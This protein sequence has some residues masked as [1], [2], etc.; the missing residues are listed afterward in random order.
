MR[1]WER[2]TGADIYPWDRGRAAIRRPHSR[3]APLTSLL[4][5][6]PSFRQLFLLQTTAFAVVSKFSSNCSF[7][8]KFSGDSNIYSSYSRLPNVILA[9][10]Y[11]IF[12]KF[13]P[14]IIPAKSLFF[15]IVQFSNNL[16]KLTIIPAIFL[17]YLFTHIQHPSVV[18]P[19]FYGVCHI[20][21]VF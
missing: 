21:L 11:C 12:R 6:M 15:L 19:V 17:C 7:F 16:F 10:R 9:F 1:I 2:E 20:F 3:P 8:G 14:M 13:L 18:L 4:Q 5:L